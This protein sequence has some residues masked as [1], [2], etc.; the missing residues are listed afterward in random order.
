VFEI[1]KAGVWVMLPIIACSILALAIIAERLWSLQTQRVMPKHLVC[2]IWQLRRMGKLTQNYIASLR[3]GSPLGRI[4]AA[5]LT[6]MHDD[7]SVMKESIEGTGPHVVYEL[8]RFL[9]TLGTIATISPLMGLLGTVMG[10]M[11][12]FSAINDASVGDPQQIADGISVAL[13]TTVAGLI[14]AI[15]SLFSYRYLYGRIDNLVINMEAEALKLIKAM[16]GEQWRQVE[17]VKGDA[18]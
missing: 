8:E 12:I 17:V 10:I 1:I 15:P 2:Q 4:L 9:N 13:I 16:R 6:N 14:V 7:R 3:D 5:G 18:A 11:R